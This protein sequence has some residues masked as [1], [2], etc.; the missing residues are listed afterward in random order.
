MARKKKIKNLETTVE[1]LKKG[2]IRIIN[3]KKVIGIDGKQNVECIETGD[4]Y[5]LIKHKN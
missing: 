5:K 2:V 1:S 3:S 4:K